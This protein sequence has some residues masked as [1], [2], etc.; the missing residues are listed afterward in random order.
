MLLVQAQASDR[1]AGDL[2]AEGVRAGVSESPALDRLTA[3]SLRRL[4]RDAGQTAE[5]RA[6]DPA[7]APPLSGY[8]LGPGGWPTPQ[9]MST[10]LVVLSWPDWP[11]VTTTRKTCRPAGYRPQPRT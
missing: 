5:T 4:D 10:S 11:G 1:T 8:T 3:Q 6:R 2:L 9:S 7:T